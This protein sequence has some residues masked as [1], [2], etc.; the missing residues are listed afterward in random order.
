VVPKKIKTT[1]V[2]RSSYHS[3]LRKAGEFHE[4]MYQAKDRNNWNAVG[5]NGVHC[6]ISSND[7]L[8]VFCA[9]IRSTSKNHNVAVDL[10]SSSIRSPEIRS[11]SETL[12]R[13]LA[14]KNLV[15]YENREF[16]QR[17]AL[18]MIKLVDRFYRWAKEKLSK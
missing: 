17:E 11:K 1:I 15:E 7:P 5:L 12:R 14:K 3:Y 2:Q 16:T 13:I 8:L 10:L 18:D 4:T 6:A 9:G